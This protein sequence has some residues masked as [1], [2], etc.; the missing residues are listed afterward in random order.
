M[1]TQLA[2]LEHKRHLSSLKIYKCNFNLHIYQVLNGID[3]V[4]YSHASTKS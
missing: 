3:K 1:V 2:I 4:A